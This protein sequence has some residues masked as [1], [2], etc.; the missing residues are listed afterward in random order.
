MDPSLIGPLPQS[1]DD[2]FLS[3]SYEERWSYLKPVIVEI[4]TRRRNGR[5][6]TL[7]DLVRFM[8]TNYSFHAAPTE[9]RRRFRDWGVSKRMVK[10]D[11]DAITSA[12]VKRKR[13]AASVSDAT[14][15]H[16]G[17]DKPLDY[18]KLKRH[19]ISRKPCLEIAP[20]LLSSCNLPYAAFVSSL[21]HP[22]EPS[23]FGSLRPTPDYL[24]IQSPE[25]LTPGRAAAGPS[26][27]MQ[28]VYEKH[29]EHCTSLFMQGRFKQ[30][31]VSMSKEDRST[32]VNYFHDF[33]MHSFI[34]A[35]N[36]GQELSNLNLTQ[37]FALTPQTPNTTSPWT[38]SAFLNL[39]SSPSSP[40]VLGATD[41]SCPPTQ[42]CKWSIHLPN[43][44][45][46]YDRSV[47]TTALPDAEILPDPEPSPRSFVESLHQSMASN[48]FTSTP[49]A[50]LPLA[51]DMIAK[52]LEEDP[53]PLQLDAWKLAIMAGNT[54]LL[55]QLYD[56]NEQEPPEDIE[57][58]HPLHLAAAFLDG[59]HQCCRTFAA[60]SWLLPSSFAFYKNIDDHG[61]TILDALVVTVL[62]SHTSLYPSAVSSGFHSSNRFPGEEKDICGRWDADTETL[63]EL[64]KQ[65]YARI[66]NQ[67]KHPFC[68][69]AVQAVCHS[70]VAIYASPAS[71]SINAQSGLFRTPS[72]NPG[73]PTVAMPEGTDVPLPEIINL[74]NDLG[75]LMAD[76]QGNY[77]Y[78][79]AESGV[80]FNTAVRSWVFNA[81][82]DKS[83]DKIPSMIKVVMPK[84]SSR[85][86]PGHQ[87][88]E[89]SKLPSK[90]IVLA[91][92]AR[93]F[94]EVHSMY[95]LFSSED[96]YLRL[97]NTYSDPEG[98]CSNSWLCS[99]HSLVALCIS[100]MP[101][102]DDLSHAQLAHTSL[103]SAK[104]YASRVT[105]EADI[106]SIR[107]LL[108]LALALQ[109]NGYLNAAYLQIGTAARIAFSLGLHLDKPFLLCRLLRG[110]EL[111]GTGKQEY[112]DELAKTCV[113][114]ATTS[115]QIFDE[116]VNE[117]SV[118]S[119]LLFDF[120]LVLAVLQVILVAST[121][122]PSEDHQ[123]NVRRCISILKAIGAHGCPKHLLPET[124]FELERLGLYHESDDQSHDPNTG[125]IQNLSSI[126]E[127]TSEDW[128]L[129]TNFDFFDVTTDDDFMDQL[130]GMSGSFSHEV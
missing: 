53:S 62:R 114:A 15:Q 14:T 36:W 58:I 41:I 37:V 78:M 120:F 30:L 61:H 66:P 76:A 34:L 20:G 26:P 96:F 33:Y 87:T 124:L 127:P 12:L 85:S 56:D 107:A 22:G 25:A 47:P 21:K 108:L 91:C 130:M 44:S 100:G 112:F 113:S 92:S 9:Y 74:H 89:P 67:W 48:D 121:L 16:D 94:E 116:M 97:E 75:C 79:G 3:C 90:D 60:L 51:Q 128:N 101:A 50:D 40:Q 28:L 81:V 57:A 7:D 104:L 77:R 117:A 99:L 83:K 2:K 122:F 64:F 86:Q 68:H 54:D 105:D 123:D 126:P 95:W 65:G 129:L 4:Y 23:P 19:L 18:K 111:V 11:K 42:L 71:P 43:A 55:Y 24:H 84:A 110:S 27:R 59:A 82:H 46:A 102:S 35:K 93:Y 39:P 98:P 52:S 115:I 32:M 125:P 29:K 49:K 38:P 13:P 31:V 119:L 73:R 5:T 63:R 69:T 8:R 72:S 70:I 10:E 118:S 109:S 1:D 106:D 6:A 88:W 80:G 45:F 103:D 17:K